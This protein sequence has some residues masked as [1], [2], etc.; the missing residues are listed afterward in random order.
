MDGMDPIDFTNSDFCRI[1]KPYI[2]EYSRMYIDEQDEH[3]PCLF[4]FGLS[5]NQANYVDNTG[6]DAHCYVDLENEFIK[7]NKYRLEGFYLAFSRYGED[8]I[9]YEISKTIIGRTLITTNEDN[10]IHLFLRKVVK[11][12]FLEESE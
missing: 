12:E 8:E 4:R 11:P 5:A 1:V 10:C 2:D 7:N 6:T 3:I 9:W